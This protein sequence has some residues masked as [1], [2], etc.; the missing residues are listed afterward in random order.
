MG[1]HD[2]RMP[3][4]VDCYRNGQVVNSFS[5]NS[6]RLSYQSFHAPEKNNERFT[7]MLHCGPRGRLVFI[8]V[9]PD[10]V[11][12]VLRRALAACNLHDRL[13]DGQVLHTRRYRHH[14]Q[15]PLSVSIPHWNGSKLLLTMGARAVRCVH[16]TLLSSKF[17]LIVSSFVAPMRVDS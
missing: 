7:S 6:L 8:V 11:V 9:A 14:T 3:N 4:S 2:Q 10:C 17:S 16:K 5:Q 13:V 1:F 15:Q 12:W